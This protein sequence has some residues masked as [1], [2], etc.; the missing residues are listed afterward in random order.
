MNSKCV[1]RGSIN[2][3]EFFY[4]KDIV[5]PGETISSHRLSKRAGGK[6]ANQAVAV[7]RAGASVTLVGSV[8]EDGC[9]VVESLKDSQVDVSDIQIVTESSGRAVIQLADDGENSIILFKGANYAQHPKK[10]LP[11]GATHVLLQN[12]IPLEDTLAYINAA[13]EASPSTVTVFNPSPVPSDAEIKEFPWDKITWLIVNE[14]EASDI[15]QALFSGAPHI[16]VPGSGVLALVPSLQD[17]TAS[18]EPILLPAA[19]LQDGV[20]DTTGAGDCFTGYLVA[21]LMKMHDERSKVLQRKE[22][23]SILKRCVQASGMCVEKR[24]ALESIPHAKDVDTRAIS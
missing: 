15:C 20:V 11:S 19:K 23:I 24:G 8:G 1:I 13:A 2:I 12:E 17:S 7:A 4:V 6:G 5:H 21:G 18:S 9:W 16:N 14:R 3:D 10:S 22:V